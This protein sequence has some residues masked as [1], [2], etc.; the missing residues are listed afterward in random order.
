ML[1]FW[2]IAFV[3][4]SDAELKGCHLV[5]PKEVLEQPE[6]LPETGPLLLHTRFEILRIRDVPD[7]GGSFGVDLMKVLNL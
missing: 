5:V 1:P 4:A 2:V 6:P 7:S 3:S